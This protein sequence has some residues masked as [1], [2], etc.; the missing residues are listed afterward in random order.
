MVCRKALLYEFSVPRDL[1]SALH[2]KPF[3]QALD[4]EN[5]EHQ[6]GPSPN[7]RRHMVRF[8]RSD[9]I[10][11][12]HCDVPLFQSVCGLEQGQSRIAPASMVVADLVKIFDL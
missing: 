1:L 5:I 12:V 11:V 8:L 9:T 4:G 3:E 7:V 2:P 10:W 6:L